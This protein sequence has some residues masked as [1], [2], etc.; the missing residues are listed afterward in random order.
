METGATE[1][2]R[3]TVP[4]MTRRTRALIKPAKEIRRYLP[5]EVVLQRFG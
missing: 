2:T 3:V 5:D 4:K 1:A